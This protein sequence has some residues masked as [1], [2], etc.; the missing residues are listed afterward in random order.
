MAV[1][2]MTRNY[3]SGVG[4]DSL[5]VQ[6]AAAS[7][8]KSMENFIGLMSHESFNSNQPSSSSSAA[9]TDLELARNTTADAAVSKF[10]R[11]ISLLDRTPTGHARFR[12]AP[13]ISPIQEIKPTP[14][15]APPQ[16]HKG[17]FSSPIKTI[18][19]SSLSSVTAESEH[20]KHH[21]H[22]RETA[23]FGTQS[24]STTVSSHHHRPSETAPFGTQSLSTTVSS[25]SKPTKRKCNSENHIAGKCASASSGRCHCSKKRKIKQRRVIRVPAISAKMSDVPPDDYSWRKYGQ[26]PIKGSPHPRG[27]YKCSSVR[28]CPARKHVERAAD[29][30]SMLIVT[31]EGDH[32]H[33][34]SAA[35]LA[36]AAVANLI[37]E[38]S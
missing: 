3:I 9:I 12:R 11:V 38:S 2:L 7:G 34:L 26:K 10:K 13:V 18:E 35:D 31:Y 15:Q 24:L 27:Y 33:S 19:F 8:L 17:S 36:G 32:N 16:I 4:V 14:F 37:L 30:S 23:P 28:G 5:A 25:F 20:M 21:H 29:D 22:R 6:E 1:E